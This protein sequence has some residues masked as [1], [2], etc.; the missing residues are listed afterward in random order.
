MGTL[1]EE[2]EGPL[3]AADAVAD[4]ANSDGAAAAAPGELED[5]EV[6]AACAEVT[7][8]EL[9]ICAR[10][11][12]LLG[13]NRAMLDS[14]RFRP[15]RK[16]LMALLD[17]A[18]ERLPDKSRMDKEGRRKHE[19]QMKRQR[20][21]LRVEADRRW[22]DNAEMRRSR[23]AALGDL[24][25]DN[26]N[27]L[28]LVPDG[29]G[30]SGAAA[31][32]ARASLTDAP[33]APAAA[34]PLALKAAGEAT[35][36]SVEEVAGDAA[37]CTADGVAAAAAEAGALAGEE[38]AELIQ[39]RAC[40]TC[41]RR[42]TVV[43]HFYDRL[44][45]PCAALNWQKRTRLVPLSSDFIA[46]VTG[47]RVKIGFEVVRKLLQAG[48]TVVAT[49]RFPRD[50]CKR[51]AAL[52]DY[53]EFRD[54]LRV[55][56]VDFRSLDSTHRLCAELSAR[57]PHLDAVV[58]N[59][60]QT[61]R[62]PARY[63]RDVARRELEPG[64][65]PACLA[66]DGGIDFSADASSAPSA[67]EAGAEAAEASAA[68]GGAL[69]LP[70]R[71]AGAATSLGPLSAAMSQAHV[72]AEDKE[73]FVAEM[74]EGAV[75]VNG[76]QLDL[77]ERHSWKLKLHEVSTEELVECLCINTVTPFVLNAK[78]KELLLKSPRAQRFIVNVSAM[79]GKFY[80]TK[81]ANHPHTNMAK[82]ALNMMTRTSAQDYV[83]EGIF[84][85]SVD[86]GW[87]NDENPLPTAHRIAAE[88]HFQSPLDEV[89]A[90]ARILD[91][92]LEPIGSGSAP[93]WGKFLKDYFE[94]E[95]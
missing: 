73:E 19:K 9:A 25:R 76:Q 1:M 7:D 42:F 95:W 11:L 92:I 72:L 69:A 75:D 82:A 51:F 49:S 45:P 47:G 32:A 13:E 93:V 59:A 31:L 14:Q 85:N 37:E 34:S 46:F 64:P 48:A 41:H 89:D 22:V 56:G 43:H 50:C 21:Q 35:C 58:H 91:P 12:T 40:Y 6:A 20:Q 60:C 54:R 2:D 18:R 80:R 61:V 17:D 28:M 39:P 63:Y 62:R 16:P 5:P 30:P 27:A 84:M 33:S 83:N 79:E 88:N 70:T 23:L 4:G 44:C 81:T 36:A 52:P 57:C 55:Y 94:T 65:A 87:I 26:A 3:A 71:A 90:A 10:V 68:E 38:E 29:S 8:E 67:T 77:R 24:Q 86:T 15:V 66:L 78:L 53:E 74:P